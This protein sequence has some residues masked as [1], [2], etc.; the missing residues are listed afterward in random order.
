VQGAL[1]G[2]RVEHA[3]GVTRGD[4]DRLGSAVDQFERIGSPLLAAEAALDLAGA[5]AAG[6]DQRAAAAA[7]AR[8]EQL[9]ARLDGPIVTPRLRSAG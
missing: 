4:G 6:G 7:R 1:I 5:E 2:A 9:L 3:V 8:A